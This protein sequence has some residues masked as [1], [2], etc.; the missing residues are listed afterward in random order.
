MKSSFSGLLE[1]STLKCLCLY[2]SEHLYFSEEDFTVLC[3]VLE[4]CDYIV[5]DGDACWRSGGQ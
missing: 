2:F 4:I 3:Y 1:I 5:V